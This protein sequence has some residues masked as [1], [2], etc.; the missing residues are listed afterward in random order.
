[1]HAINWLAVGPSDRLGL[2]VFFATAIHVMVIFGVSFGVEFKSTTTPNTIEVLLI[3]TESSAPPDK[4][5]H[6]A[7]AD[8]RASGNK[9]IKN[10][11]TSP[12]SGPSP[13]PTSGLARMSVLPTAATVSAPTE[14]PILTARHAAEKFYSDK[15]RSPDE[16]D[17]SQRG[18]TRQRRKLEIAQL[19]AELSK[20]EQRYS[21]R[22]RINYIDTLSAKSAVEATY[23]KDWVDTVERMGNLNYPDE[24]RRRNL[25]GS[26]ILHVLLNNDGKV[27]TV[28]I[29]MGSGQQV[30]D[31]AALRIVTLA[32]P[33]KPFPEE[34]RAAY[35]QLMITRTWVF[36]GGDSLVTR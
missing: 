8:Q 20:R 12:T 9:S 15:I 6:I 16:M 19:T 21:M 25:S 2:T 11:P 5:E 24:A 3:Q 23:I 1:M 10:R 33:F 26:L 27:V 32:A 17:R 13:V 14:S 34:M 4:A 7:Q 36:Q 29:G 28:E 30:L 35:D 22:P 18:K 31:D